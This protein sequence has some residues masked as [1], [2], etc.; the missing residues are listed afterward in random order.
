MQIKP[1]IRVAP[2]YRISANGNSDAILRIRVACNGAT[3]ELAVGITVDADRWNQKLQKM[4]GT[5]EDSHGNVPHKV[6]TT[7]DEFK[8]LI[9]N[10]FSRYELDG[11]MPARHKMM[12]D[13]DDVVMLRRTGY[14]D[15]TDLPLHDVMEKFMDANMLRG[16]WSP[17]TYAKYVTLEQDILEYDHGIRMS[18]FTEDTLYR[19]VRFFVTSPRTRI[20]GQSR[21]DRE[22]AGMKNSTIVRKVKSIKCFLRWADDN[23]YL[24]EKA[25]R[26][27]KPRLDDVNRTVI[28]LEVEELQQ[29]AAFEIPP[30][31]KRYE[32]VRDL[33]IFG[34]F[35]GLRFSDIENLRKSDVHDGWFGFTTI[36]TRD[37]L[38]VPKN[39]TASAILR[40]YRDR[41]IKGDRALPQMS[42]QKMN[43]R[44]KELA[45]MAGI[46][47]PVHLEYFR[48]RERYDIEGP[49]WEFLTSHAG[50]RTF[51]SFAVN[52]GVPPEIV[53][54][55][56]GHS[57]YR[58]MKPYI[59]GMNEISAR[60]MK[61]FD[62]I[63]IPIKPE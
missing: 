13:L 45:Q 26:R 54:Q 29:L 46:D 30:G 35:T 17:R 7:I 34:C 56:T 53:R 55:W 47:A 3:K 61:K 6:N 27:F 25:Y 42:N 1:N 4:E 37:S 28:K 60:E 10:L 59:A 51:I 9:Q 43:M 62:M 12:K 50:R 11:T 49:K 19:I 44:L 23:G 52:S 22:E 58:A 57:S 33:L 5:K 15:A 2:K 36:K 14:T 48:G 41:P 32:E 20:R 40:K 21:K 8:I 24:K 31:K 16:E 18:D 38:G 39:R 63:E